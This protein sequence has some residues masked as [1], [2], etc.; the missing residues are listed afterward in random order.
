MIG[1]DT[2]G[3][4]SLDRRHFLGATGLSLVGLAGCQALSDDEDPDGGFEREIEKIDFAADY[5]DRRSASLA[6]WPF[7]ERTA[8]PTDDVGSSA[9]WLESD[10]VQSAPWTPPEGWED[11]PAADVD[12]IRFLNYGDMAYDPATAAVDALFERETGITVERVEVVMEQAI[13]KAA[14]FL[15]QGQSSP[16]LLQATT[17]SSMSTYAGAGWLQTVDAVMPDEE[18][19]EMYLPVCKETYNWNGHL[20]GGPGTLEGVPMN[21]RVDLLEEQGLD[22][23]LEKIREGT[24]TWD[25]METVMAAFEGTD[26]YGFGFRGGSDVDAERDWRMLWYQTGGR[27]VDDDGTVTIGESGVIALEKLIEWKENGWL[28]P[29]SVS[30]SEGDLTDAFLS[31]QLAMAAVATDIVGDASDAFE[32]DDEYII[33]R[34]PAATEGP[35][36]QHAT[37]GGGPVSAIN[38][39]ASTG[40]K[41]AGA[42]YQDCRF[43]EAA[44][45]WEYAHEGNMAPAT[46]TYEQAAETDAIWLSGVR[47]Q[48]MADATNEV[49]PQQRELAQNTAEEIQLAYAGEKEPAAAI[50]DAQSFIDTVLDQ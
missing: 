21:V 10:S 39:H 42:L 30:W 48:V 46:A 26:V 23:E 2:P 19:W 36:P 49:F 47:E 7:E 11:T 24:W 1:D 20:W 31:G 12:T 50:E 17:S 15:S 38:V 9:A 6:E 33:A 16:Q 45:W 27:Y 25:D 40:Q 5:R 14:A 28:P 29:E 43:S 34:M 41:V 4:P 44:S 8:V 22:A 37:Y 3:G 32:R 18:M 13:P 35:D